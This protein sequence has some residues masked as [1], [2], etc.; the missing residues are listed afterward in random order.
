MMWTGLLWELLVELRAIF[1]MF[2]DPR[3]RL[4]W[5]MRVG[6]LVL[7]IAIFTSSLWIPGMVVMKDWVIGTIVDKVVDLL[8]AWVLYKLLSREAQRYRETAPD[9]PANLRL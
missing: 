9:L 5:R 8:L 1:C 4:G 6:G 2:V 7:V 3:Y